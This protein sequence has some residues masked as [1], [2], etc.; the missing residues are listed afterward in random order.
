MQPHSRFYLFIKLGYVIVESCNTAC[1]KVSLGFWTNFW[2]GRR[3]RQRECGRRKRC[4]CKILINLKNVDCFD[5]QCADLFPRLRHRFLES[6]RSKKKR[7]SFHRL[8]LEI[9]HHCPSIYLSIPFE[10]FPKP[11][12]VTSRPFANT[13]THTNRSLEST[14]L[15]K[16]SFWTMCNMCKELMRVQNFFLFSKNTFRSS[17]GQELY[18][19]TKSPIVNQTRQ[20]DWHQVVAHR[21]DK[22]FRC[23]ERTLRNVRKGHPLSFPCACLSGYL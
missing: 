8:L 9:S 2:T 15:L 4:F 13:Y 22:H 16:F 20:T 23:Y 3:R 19:Y 17:L 12:S 21:S 11:V 10:N 5:Y 14:M 18:T 6:S 7:Q 1:R